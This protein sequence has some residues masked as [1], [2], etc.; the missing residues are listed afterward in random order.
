MARP[1]AI[2]GEAEA[3][4]WQEVGASPMAVIDVQ[5]KAAIT[6]RLR[7]N[8]TRYPSRRQFL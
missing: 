6:A 1:S 8:F 3:R 2:G 4:A 5:E 7:K